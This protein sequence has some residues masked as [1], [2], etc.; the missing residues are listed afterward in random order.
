MAQLLLAVAT[1]GPRE[2]LRRPLLWAG[3]AI[4]AVLVT[5]T[6][7]WQHVHGWPQLR[8]ASVVAGEA[9][10][11]YGG[12]PGIAVQMVVFAG[13]AGVALALYGLWRLFRDDALRDY[14]FLAVTFVAM[15]VAFLATAGRPY[16]LAGLYA[17]LAAAGALAMQRR[18][19]TRPGPARVAGMARI[20]AERSTGRRRACV[21][22]VGRP[23][24]RR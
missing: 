5:P 10:A 12:R 3:A 21:V 1:V 22:G 14:R 9:D 2:L 17:P 11:L 4:A 15:Y 8:M 19:E 13:V 20:P 7:I 6:F 16:Y 23:V 24:R 18:R